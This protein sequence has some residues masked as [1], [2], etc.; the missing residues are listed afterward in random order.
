MPTCSKGSIKVTASGTAVLTWKGTRMG[1]LQVRDES[2]EDT[3][4][5]CS[6]PDGFM[7]REITCITAQVREQGE[8]VKKTVDLGGGFAVDVDLTVDTTRDIT[9]CEYDCVQTEP[10]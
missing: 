7:Y 6:C 2:A 5:N 9:N 1:T 8:Q 3:W 10:L 4:D